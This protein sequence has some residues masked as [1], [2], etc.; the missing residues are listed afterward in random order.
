MADGSVGWHR[1]EETVRKTQNR[2][3]SNWNLWDFAR[4]DRNLIEFNE[5]LPNP[6]KISLDLLEISP[7]FRFFRQELE[8]F[9]RNLRFSLESRNFY[10]NLGFSLESRFFN[11]QFGFWGEG[12]RNRP[13]EVSFW[14]RKPAVDRR[15]SRID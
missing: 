15:S 6:V 11:G 2:W 10:R 4:S 14:W 1:S 8:N 3:K 12:N 13:I 9:H 5:I 7:K